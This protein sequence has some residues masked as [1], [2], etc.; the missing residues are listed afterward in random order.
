MG[1]LSERLGVLERAVAVLQGQGKGAPLEI[2][3]SGAE[4]KN[5]LLRAASTG[6]D[7]MDC[8]ALTPQKSARSEML[9]RMH[10][11]SGIPGDRHQHG[12]SSSLQ[13]PPAA[14]VETPA[15]A[16]HTPDGPKKSSMRSL[17]R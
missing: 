16:T 4:V 7:R 5:S 10:M 14:T 12:L 9:P 17:L 8:A 3:G 15:L 13:R 11:Q 2:R 1:A 6:L